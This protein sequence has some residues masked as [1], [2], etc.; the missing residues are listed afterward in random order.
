MSFFPRALA[1]LVAVALV[2]LGACGGDDD[3]DARAVDNSKSKSQEVALPGARLRLDLASIDVQS[4]GPAANLD[5]KTKV[6]VMTQTRK[7]VTEAIVRP[8]LSGKNVR[9]AYAELFA[10]TVSAAATK[11]DRPALTDEGVGKVSGDVRAGRTRVTMN[12][13]LGGDG[14]I[15]IIA[16][17][18]NLRVKSDLD[19]APLN[20]NRETELT[21]ERT[22]NGKW[23]VS[24][25]RVV[26]TRS[27][28]E[29]KAATT[30]SSTARNS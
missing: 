4:A 27:S 14:S 7:Y 20:I 13:L 19:K 6:A 2:A 22:P 5:E 26:T 3:D 23:L 25:Y 12:A 9:P 15:Q 16:T 21:F 1:G 29:G 24:A 8:L 10:P 11:A 28:G 17:R 18:F 30:E